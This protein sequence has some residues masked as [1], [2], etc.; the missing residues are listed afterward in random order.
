MAKRAHR[1]KWFSNASI[2]PIILQLTSM[3]SYKIEKVYL[4]IYWKG[5][6]DGR[7]KSQQSRALDPLTIPGNLYIPLIHI[8]KKPPSSEMISSV[9]QN[10]FSELFI[11]KYDYI[12]IY[13]QYTRIQIQH[14]TFSRIKKQYLKAN[15]T[16]SKW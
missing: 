6:L 7:Y 13:K 2:Y 11:D 16:N 14:I 15:I 12:P 1:M 3:Y 5:F 9:P 4:E 8:I 10:E